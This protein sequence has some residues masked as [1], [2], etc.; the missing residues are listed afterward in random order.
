MN[1]QQ[2]MRVR[3]PITNPKLVHYCCNDDH[4][5]TALSFL[6]QRVP[7]PRDR[8][9]MCVRVHVLPYDMILAAYQHAGWPIEPI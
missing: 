3:C 6:C 7:P 9:P 8:Y 5:S 2:Q 1:D 4:P